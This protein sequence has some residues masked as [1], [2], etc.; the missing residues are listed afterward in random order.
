METVL[1][2]NVTRTKQQTIRNVPLMAVPSNRIHSLLFAP[3]IEQKQTTPPLEHKQFNGAQKQ[4][5]QWQL[6]SWNQ[7]YPAQQ[8]HHHHH[9]A[10]R[11]TVS[12]INANNQLN[13]GDHQF[14]YETSFMP[15][16]EHGR[17]LCSLSI[18]QITRTFDIVTHELLNFVIHLQLGFVDPADWDIVHTEYVYRLTFAEQK[19]NNESKA[20]NNNSSNNDDA[21]TTLSLAA[22]SSTIATAPAVPKIMVPSTSCSSSSSPLMH[23]GVIFAPTNTKDNNN[24]DHRT[25]DLFE[26]NNSSATNTKRR[27]T[28]NGQITPIPVTPTMDSLMMSTQRNQ[29]TLDGNALLRHSADEEG[30]VENR[31]NKLVPNY[32]QFSV[33]N[34]PYLTAITNHF[35]LQITGLAIWP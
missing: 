9:Y 10:T 8:Q 6:H 22:S 24:T 18:V 5:H 34:G 2:N 13:D 32:E 3:K 25:D 23:S 28:E 11:S 4:G 26:S 31:R 35:L 33:A 27:K 12:I 1:Y 14:H 20:V 30:L 29:M 15:R 17:S 19:Q 21:K 16:D 7:K